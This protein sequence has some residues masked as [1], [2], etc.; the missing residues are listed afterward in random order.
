MN[1]T[2]VQ[3]PEQ[4]NP[5]PRIADALLFR[6]KATFLQV[7]R[8][9]REFARNDVQRF[10]FVNALTGHPI[11]GESQTPLWT[12]SD[13]AEKYL[14]AG[15]IHNLRLAIRRLNGVEVAA[16]QVF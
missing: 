5:A 10:P 1:E 4:R 12:K 7:R 3:M 13:D 2:T 8:A 6:S 15:K 9:M 14:I 16:E 11:I